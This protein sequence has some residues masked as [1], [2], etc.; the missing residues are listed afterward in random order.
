M[1]IVLFLTNGAFGE[2]G[3]LGNQSS[4]GALPTP[5]CVRVV[6]VA[7]KYNYCCLDSRDV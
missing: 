4:S 6:L 2:R 7:S 1:Y 3:I 5:F